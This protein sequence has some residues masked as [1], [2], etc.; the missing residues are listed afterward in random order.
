MTFTPRL[1]S[2]NKRTAPSDTSDNDLHTFVAVKRRKY[3]EDN[4]RILLLLQKVAQLERR[5]EE[6][7][8]ELVGV[9]GGAA[10]GDA[11]GGVGRW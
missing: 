11:G 10:C 6:F 1:I 5:Q 9:D 3:E 7:A 4:E 8:R 2:R